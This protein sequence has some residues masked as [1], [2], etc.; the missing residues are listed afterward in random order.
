MYNSAPTNYMLQYRVRQTADV[1]IVDLDG[2]ITLGEALR[3][4][5]SPPMDGQQH[6]VLLGGVVRDLLNEGHRKILL[7]LQGVTYIDSSGIGELVGA[8]T[9]VRQRGGELKLMNPVVRVINL[10][11]ITRLDNLFPVEADEASAVRAFS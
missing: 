3:Y 7:N 2:P 6:P 4:G 9:S 11:R 1:S 8:F 10:L 5:S